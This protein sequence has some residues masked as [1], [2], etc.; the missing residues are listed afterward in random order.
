M[1]YYKE[2]STAVQNGDPNKVESIISRALKEG[3]R[4]NDLLD[5]GLMSG[6]EVVGEKFGRNEM[7]IPEVMMSAKCLQ[8]G[9]DKLKPL[10]TAGGR[11]LRGSLVIGT[12]AGDVHD[13]GKNL[14]SMMFTANGFDVVDLGVDVAP[15]RF[16]EAVEKYKPDFLGLSALLTTTMSQMSK[17]VAYLRDKNPNRSYKIIVGGAPVTEEFAA[18][19]G[20]DYYADNAIEAVELARSVMEGN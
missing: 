15:E 12:V 9:M 5:N 8:C 10:F 17:T 7:F 13:L 4:A 11:K 6:I 18:E 2:L 20:A 19:I 1:D 16:A 14:V 3:Y